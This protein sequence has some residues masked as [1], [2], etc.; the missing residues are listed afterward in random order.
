MYIDVMITLQVLH[1]VSIDIN[2]SLIIV[3]PLLI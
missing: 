1:S 3:M 2:Y